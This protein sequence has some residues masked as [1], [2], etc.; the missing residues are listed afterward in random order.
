MCL[1]FLLSL[2]LA[3]S[4]SLSLSWSW[5]WSWSSSLSSPP[6]PPPP[7]SSSSLFVIVIV[8]VSTPVIA[9]MIVMSQRQAS[10][11][12]SYVMKA[13]LELQALVYKLL[14][15]FLSRGLNKGNFLKDYILMLRV[16]D[17]YALRTPIGLIP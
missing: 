14:L 6:S 2:L 11:V 12:T 7:P 3:L 1:L 10:C 17:E 13:Q 15:D 5:S 8:V 16:L 9:T 4:L